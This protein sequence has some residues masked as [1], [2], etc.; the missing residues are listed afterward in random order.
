MILHNLLFFPPVS[1]EQPD[2]FDIIPLHL[3]A[4][5]L[6]LFTDLF[7]VIGHVDI[8]PCVRA[9]KTPGITANIV[10]V[11]QSLLK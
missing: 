9:H 8:P 2:Q 11:I 4:E 3:L 1:R 5:F 10:P 6:H 7:S